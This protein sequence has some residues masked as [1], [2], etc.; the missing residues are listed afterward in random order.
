MIHYAKKR[1]GMTIGELRSFMKGLPDDLPVLFY[2]KD[3]CWD[4]TSS[5]E[6]GVLQGDSIVSMEDIDED[7]EHDKKPNCIVLTGNHN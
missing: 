1:N 4:S 7:D 2:L 5:V 6:L 3:D